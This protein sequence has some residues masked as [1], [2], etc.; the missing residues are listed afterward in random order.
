MAG[1][2]TRSTWLNGLAGLLVG[3]AVILR[4]VNA[5]LP[6]STWRTESWLIGAG[7]IYGVVAVYAGTTTRGRPPRAELL[8]VAMNTAFTTAVLAVAA[9]WL[10]GLAPLA[11]LVGVAYFL[12]AAALGSSRHLL[13]A[14]AIAAT[15]P[16]VLW[17]EMLLVLHRDPFMVLAWVLLLLGIAAFAVSAVR[18]TSERMTRQMR[19]TN[20]IAIAAQAVGLSTDLNQVAAAVLTASRVV[21][22][23]ADFGGVLLFDHESEKL[24]PLS[25]S[26][27]AGVIGEQP[28]HAPFDL[29]PGEGVAGKAFLAAEP[30]CWGTAKEV[31][32]EHGN[33]RPLTREQIAAMTGGVS[34]GAAAPMI[35]PDR[36]VIG[37]LTL[38]S[39]IREGV[40]GPHDMVV[41]Q[42]LAEQAAL[43]VERARMYQEQRAQ[44]L[45]DPLT[46]LANYRQLKNVVVQEVA[47]ARRGDSRVAV[48]FCDLDGFKGVNDVHGHRTGDGVLRVLART[49]SEVLR[50]EDL[51]ARY[52][53]DEFVCILPGA[54][55]AQAV[56][57][58]ERIADRFGELLEADDEL[59]RVR[60]FPTCG[61][62]LYPV[63]GSNAE[64]IIAA[65]DAALI[66]AKRSVPHS[67]ARIG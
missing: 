10:Y 57:V 32:A 25:T 20:A 5:R 30:R 9:P 28:D 54:D 23:D 22:S 62:A 42:G 29:S 48:I 24:K 16:L 11:G 61:C 38:G 45:T 19:R 44:A 13:V 63:H 59:S 27:V 51:A 26:M 43:G 21:F 6:A 53:G 36:G 52:G 50:A 1:R 47:R 60:T 31:V 3:T 8:V 49:M 66:K 7:V 15:G 46:G 55:M 33:M 58:S 65:A 35:L 39:S 17:L 12:G 41:L 4:L 14:G 18:L 67:D 56:R 2:E 64:E 34:S 37:V 40:W